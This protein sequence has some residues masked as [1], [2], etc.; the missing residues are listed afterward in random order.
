[1]CV[2]GVVHGLKF[3]MLKYAHNDMR[4]TLI[5]LIRNCI[6]TSCIDHDSQV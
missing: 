4:V 3:S 2:G 5:L 1:M 6:L